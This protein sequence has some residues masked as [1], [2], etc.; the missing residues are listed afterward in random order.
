MWYVYFLQL[1]NDDICVGSS[2]D[3]RRRST[4][5]ERGQMKSPKACLPL[6]LKS[7]IAAQTEENAR[8]LER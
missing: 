4:S 2:N 8:Q 5:H 1:N 6:T 3:L 7:Y